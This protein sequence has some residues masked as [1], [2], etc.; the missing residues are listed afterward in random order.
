MLYGAA[1]GIVMVAGMLPEGIPTAVRSSQ[2]PDWKPDGAWS[3][4][5]DAQSH[6]V[7]VHKLGNLAIIPREIN[8]ALSNRPFELRGI[9]LFTYEQIM[10]C[11][12]M[13][14]TIHLL[15]D[16]CRPWVN[17]ILLMFAGSTI[18]T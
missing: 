11:S 8:S 2:K 1:A 10:P 14:Y 5:F 12:Q 18:T 3:A 13:H 16:A 9:R 15:L 7:L 17:R 4:H 6:R